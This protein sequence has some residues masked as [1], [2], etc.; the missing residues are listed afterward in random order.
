[1]LELLGRAVERNLCSALDLHGEQTWGHFAT[2]AVCKLWDWSSWE[3]LSAKH[4]RVARASALAPLSI[5][6]IGRGVFAAWC[7]DSEAT[8]AIIAEYNAVNEATG[9]GWWSA[10][11]LLYAAYQGQS[12]GLALIMA[13]EK[14][15]AKNEVGQGVQFA[16]YTRTISRDGLGRY[17]DALVVAE[18]AAYEMEIPTGGRYLS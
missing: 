5:A 10:G 1:V 17:S 2:A 7:G 3:I 15:S 8:A 18:L 4:V 6:L 13:S 12:D 14:D 9:I 11:G 16:A